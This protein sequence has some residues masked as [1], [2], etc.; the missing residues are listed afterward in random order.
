MTADAAHALTPSVDIPAGATRP[1]SLL[2]AGTA[3]AVAAAPEQA[4]PYVLFGHHRHAT[5][6]SPA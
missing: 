2:H 4:Q 6:P 3:Q 5:D 1:C